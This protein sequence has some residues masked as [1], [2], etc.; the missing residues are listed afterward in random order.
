MKSHASHDIVLLCTRCHSEGAAVVDR[1]KC[2][3]AQRHGILTST[4]KYIVDKKATQIT[5][6]AKALRKSGL[7]LPNKRREEMEKTIAEYMG[8][9]GDIC[10]SSDQLH[11]A[12][13]IQTHH[14][15]PDYESIESRL[16]AKIIEHGHEY[17]EL[18]RLIRS[19]RKDFVQKMKPKFLPDGWHVDYGLD[20]LT[21]SQYETMIHG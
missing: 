9:S 20:I 8:L 10:L 2:T 17:A 15:N 6:Y 19:F 13:A 14:M 21:T 5:K 4:M 16:V 3:L 7:K 1:M 11:E 12:E 18:Q